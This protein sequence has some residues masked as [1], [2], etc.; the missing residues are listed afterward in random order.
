MFAASGCT[1]MSL[2]ECQSANWERLGFES[3]MDGLP[4]QNATQ[5]YGKSCT[6]KHGVQIS[7]QE[8]S[9]GYDMGLKR[10]CTPQQAQLTGQALKEYAG[11]CPKEMETEFLRAYGKGQMTGLLRK[12]SDLEGQVSSLKSEL[13]SK[14]SEISSLRSQVSN[15]GN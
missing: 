14:D 10:Y 7:L 13:S 9:K 6:E 4:L 8:F 12:V 3:A 11:V 5:K 15:C 1:S 2:S